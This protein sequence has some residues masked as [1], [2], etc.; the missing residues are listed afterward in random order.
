ME[1]GAAYFKTRAQQGG[2]VSFSTESL[3]AAW[4]SLTD[5]VVIR[6]DWLLVVRVQLND[7]L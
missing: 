4:L 5:S 2:K 1:K 3:V 7:C 6:I